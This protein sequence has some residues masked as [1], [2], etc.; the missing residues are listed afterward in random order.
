MATSVKTRL[1]VFPLH[2]GEHGAIVKLNLGRALQSVSKPEASVDFSVW[3][4]RFSYRWYRRLKTSFLSQ[5]G[6]AAKAI[7]GLKKRYNNRYFNV[8]LV[9]SYIP[10]LPF[11]LG[12][13]QVVVSG[14]SEFVLNVAQLLTKMGIPSDAVVLLD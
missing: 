2:H 6:R 8:E 12:D 4:T 10:L 5:F 9:A 13:P 14:P 7:S 11:A 3:N 1:D